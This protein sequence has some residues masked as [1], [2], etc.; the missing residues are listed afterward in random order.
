MNRLTDNDRNFGP[1]TLA[2][3]RKT[4]SVYIESGDDEHPE[5]TI[6]LI[7][8]GWALRI[9]VW[10][11]LCRPWRARCVECNWDAE[12]V[13]RLGRSGY[14][15]IHE[16]RYGV[17]LSDM[18]N[19]YDFLQVFY[20][21][22]THDSSTTKSWSKHLPWKQWEHVRTSIYAPTGEHFCTEVRGAGADFR[23]WLKKEDECPKVHF[24][25][26]DFDGEMIVATCMIEEREWRK[27]T[28]WFKWLRLFA[29]PKILRSL[30]LKF[31]AEVGPEKGSWK[32]GTI[33][34]GIDMLTGET[35]RQAFERYCSKE[36]DARRGRKYHVRFIGQCS[37]P[38]ARRE[39]SEISQIP[40]CA[41]RAE[42]SNDL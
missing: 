39:T 19:G 42:L 14:W 31:S 6:L 16:R 26:E 4:F 13:K 38:E 36:H 3:W 25:F 41:T 18:G 28:G 15:E 7:A 35:P 37:A 30:D 21:T 8:F 2:R 29:K 24:G 9:R 1:F 40:K 20:G 17:S 32:G 11:W 23:E 34:H 10:S 33:G 5:T 27:G 12:T 22:Y